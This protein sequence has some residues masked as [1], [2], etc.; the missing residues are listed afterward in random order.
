MKEKESKGEYL[1]TQRLS[2][3]VP[4]RVGLRAGECPPRLLIRARRSLRTSQLISTPQDISPGD[5]GLWPR[6]I[7]LLGNTYLTH[8]GRFLHPQHIHD[9]DTIDDC[10]NNKFRTFSHA[11]RLRRVRFLHDALWASDVPAG[12]G[13]AA[14]LARSGRRGVSL[15]FELLH[16]S[17]VW[18]TC[19]HVPSAALGCDGG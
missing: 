14:R 1:W 9:S 2:S 11:R 6:Y 12:Y 3:A 18:S 10:Q 16:I 7:L 17:G 5:L 13:A 4:S 8:V 19:C 15:S